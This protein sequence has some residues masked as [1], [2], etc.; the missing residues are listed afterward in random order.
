M[1][2]AQTSFRTLAATTDQPYTFD[3][4]FA[5]NDA[6]IILTSSDGVSY[7]VHAFTLRTTSGFFRDMIS[8]PQH[9]SPEGRED[10]INLDETSDVLGNLLRMISGFGVVKWSSYDEVESVLAAAQKYDMRGPLLTIR[11]AI[12]SPFFLEQP[13]RLYAIA[14]RYEWEEEA[15]LASKYSLRL[16]LHDNEHTKILD[17]IPTAY[18]LRLFRLHR[19]RRDE[20]K[21]HV[22][23]DNGCFGIQN[24]PYCHQCVQNS[25]LGHLTNLI[26]WEMDRHPAGN[27]LLEGRWKEWPVYKGIACTEGG[28]T[29][30]S[31][32]YEARISADIKFCLQSL[33]STI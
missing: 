33:S 28:G 7:R 16:S 24:C 17:R 1:A 18:I 23:R 5:E 32:G 27:E 8:L 29:F 31:L 30:S 21:T 9:D 14:A 25:A 11:S 13:L 22:T 10:T 6:K 3:V 12:T 19:S 26:I 2:D 4:A 15:R 20:F